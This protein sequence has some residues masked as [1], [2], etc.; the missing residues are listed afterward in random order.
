MNTQTPNNENVDVPAL[1]GTGLS[2]NENR[3]MADN[4]SSTPQLKNADSISAV[5]A[6]AKRG[7][8]EESGDWK[9][10]RNLPDVEEVDFHRQSNAGDWMPYWERMDEV[11]Q[12]C[13]NVVRAAQDRGSKYVIFTHGWSTSRIGKTTA[14]SQVR[15]FMRSSEATPFII[16]SRCIQHY[17]VFVAAIRPKTGKPVQVAAK[18]PIHTLNA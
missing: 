18:D 7:F 5:I 6:K 11:T 13:L 14:R 8:R 15:K 9:E 17:S 3:E 16:R 4:N 12:T 2:N 1:G 10:Y